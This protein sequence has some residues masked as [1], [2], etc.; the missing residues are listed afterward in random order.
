MGA[1]RIVLMTV[2]FSRWWNTPTVTSDSVLD[3]RTAERQTDS[4]PTGSMQTQLTGLRDHLQT[5]HADASLLRALSDTFPSD[6][7]QLE[8]Q[9]YHYNHS[10]DWVADL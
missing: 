2:H 1:E 9:L 7:Q 4:H 6:G 3:V 8:T 10:Q 5:S